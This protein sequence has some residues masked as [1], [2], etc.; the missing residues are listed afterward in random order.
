MTVPRRYVEWREPQSSPL[1]VITSYVNPVPG[2]PPDVDD[3]E[4]FI[5]D[6]IYVAGYDSFM[7]EVAM[8]TPPFPVNTVDCSVQI[9]NP[10]NGVSLYSQFIGSAGAAET[11]MPF[12]AGVGAGLNVPWIMLQIYATSD[13]GVVGFNIQWRLFC[14]SR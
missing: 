6:T 1:G 3:A 14:A 13:G 9:V 10:D 11:R 8:T 7:L 5:S 4:V 2:L 12:G